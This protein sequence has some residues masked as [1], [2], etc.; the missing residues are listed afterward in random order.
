MIAIRND[1]FVVGIRH[2]RIRPM[3][4]VIRN[5]VM[6]VRENNAI[7]AEQQQYFYCYYPGTITTG[8]RHRPISNRIDNAVTGCRLSR[9]QSFQLALRGHRAPIEMTINNTT[10]HI[11]Q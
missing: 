10:I 1:G 6:F 4:P 9:R 7:F 3:T 8:Q 2:G 11:L 5:N